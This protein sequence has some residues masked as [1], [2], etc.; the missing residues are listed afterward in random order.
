MRNEFEDGDDAI[1]INRS[2]IAKY[3]LDQ[4]VP[5]AKGTCIKTPPCL[6][7]DPLGGMKVK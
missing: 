2:V 5:T 4:P 1:A 7:V 6:K 3:V